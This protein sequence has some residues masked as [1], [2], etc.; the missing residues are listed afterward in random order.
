M[1]PKTITGKTNFYFETGF[2]GIVWIVEPAIVNSPEDLGWVAAGD[3]LTITS[4]EGE[5]LFEGIIEPD[6][7]V[8]KAISD[9][10]PNRIQPCA[11]G[12][13]IHWTQTG[14]EP[15]EWAALFVESKNTAVLVK[16]QSPLKDFEE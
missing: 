12:Y 3:H 4:P 8:G 7:E 14:F 1:A 13:W 15:D 16:N 11:L 2:E 6:R 10:N 9:L 5:V